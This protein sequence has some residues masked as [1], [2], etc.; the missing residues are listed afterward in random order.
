MTQ[1]AP[2]GTLTPV[3]RKP[4]Y[5]RLVEH[6]RAYVVDA[7]LAAG[8]RLPSERELSEGL[9]VS[10]A[11]IRQAIVALEVQ[12]IV[13]VRHG[14]GAFLRVPKMDSLSM[15]QLTDLR[16]RLPDILDAREAIEV[17]FASLAAQRRTEADLAGAEVALKRMETEIRAGGLG[18]E[19]DSD[20]HHWV[21]EAARSEVLAQMYAVI[22]GDIAVSRHESRNQLPDPNELL[23]Q[24]RR[25]ADAIFARDE[26]VAAESMRAHLNAVRVGKLESWA[27]IPAD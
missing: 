11:S 26:M 27:S 3:T 18:V 23:A 17:M 10:R 14:E 12:G 25:I 2:V 7:G 1:R 24:H 5:E 9:G 13:E 15:V 4:L 8:D 16:R 21:L 22:A 6:L 19:G 20:F